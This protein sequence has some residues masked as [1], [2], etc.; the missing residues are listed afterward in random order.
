MTKKLRER[1]SKKLKQHV[2]Q[3]KLADM[4]KISVRTVQCWEQ[5]TRF[6][7]R[8]SRAAIRS[9]AKKHSVGVDLD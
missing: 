1:L 6:P 3:K 4:L 9:I 8:T 5:G 2:S 7:G